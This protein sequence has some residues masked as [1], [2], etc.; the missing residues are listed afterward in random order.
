MA[1]N[2]P[3]PVGPLHRTIRNGFVPL[4]VVMCVEGDRAT[5]GHPAKL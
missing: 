3:A 2:T 5:A 4:H 1:T